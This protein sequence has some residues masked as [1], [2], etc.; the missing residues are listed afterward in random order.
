ME[1]ILN[2]KWIKMPRILQVNIGIGNKQTIVESQTPRSFKNL[3]NEVEKELN[4]RK[5]QS[6]EVK[7]KY[8]ENL[9][10]LLKKVD[11]EEQEFFELSQFVIYP[12]K[13]LPEK[14]DVQDASFLQCLI[15]ALS[16]LLFA[17]D[18]F[19]FKHEYLNLSLKGKTLYGVYFNSAL[20]DLKD[21]L[22]RLLSELGQRISHMPP[23]FHFMIANCM[24]EHSL[25]ENKIKRIVT[26]ITGPPTYIKPLVTGTHKCFSP[27]SYLIN[28]CE[29]VQQAQERMWSFLSVS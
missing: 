13:T 12:F 23:N 14:K 21:N 6:E 27:T 16:I 25:D 20:H 7:R 3:L 8:I 22:V 10:F 4:Q 17:S 28:E 19:D 29:N 11:A 2:K 15:D 26:S 5:F 1:K 18:S 24:G 9:R